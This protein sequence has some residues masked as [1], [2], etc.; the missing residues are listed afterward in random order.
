MTL[1]QVGE[2]KICGTTS[3][4]YIDEDNHPCVLEGT[5]KEARVCFKRSFNSCWKNTTVTIHGCKGGFLVYQL[6][7]IPWDC[8]LRYCGAHRPIFHH[9]FLSSRAIPKCL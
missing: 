6:P 2:E 9:R 1:F 8:T 4:G 3:P 5:S 7:T